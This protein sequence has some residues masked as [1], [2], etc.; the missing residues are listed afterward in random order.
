MTENSSVISKILKGKDLEVFITLSEYLK[1][2]GNL[3]NML[4]ECIVFYFKE[5]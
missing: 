3:I 2:S 1:N 5:V 4:N